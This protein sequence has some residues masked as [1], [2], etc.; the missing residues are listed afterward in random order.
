MFQKFNLA[1]FILIALFQSSCFASTTRTII[2][3]R[4]VEVKIPVNIQ[5]VATISDGLVEGIM[6]VFGVQDKL[7]AVGSSCIQRNFQ[8]TFPS[9]DGTEHTYD[10]G[11]NPVFYLNPWINNL[12]CISQSS[13]PINYEVLVKTNPDVVLARIGS[14]TLRHIDDENAQKSIEML[15]SIGI[16]VIVLYGTTCHEKPSVSGIS[17]EISIIGNVFNNPKKTKELSDYLEAQIQFIKDRTNGIKESDKENTI[18]FGLSPRARKNGGAGQIFGLDTIESF[19][20]ETIANAKNAYRESG[21]F[22]TINTEQILKIDPDVIVLCTA[23]G[24]HPPKELYNAPYYQ[25]LQDLKAVRNKRIAALPWSPCNCSKR[26]EYPIDAM[27]IATASYPDIFK[28]ITLA[29]WLLDF[30]KNVYGVDNET[31]KKLRSVQWMDWTLEE[32]K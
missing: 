6:T 32:I 28:D 29:D 19:F 11:M 25:N 31:A 10:D 23:Y 14:C 4:G 30:Y 17:N 18:I 24:Y 3:S 8:Y 13:S 2:D 7:V 20:I 26:L 1:I 9:V 15:E 16:P 27:V 22:R 12:P 21:Y 5:R